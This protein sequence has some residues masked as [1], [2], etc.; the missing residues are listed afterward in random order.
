M[1]FSFVRLALAGLSAA[2]LG[3]IVSGQSSLSPVA[4]VCTAAPSCPTS[5]VSVPPAWYNLTFSTA[6]G[7]TGYGWEATEAGDASCAF[8]HQGIV[9]FNASLS[10]YV[11]LNNLTGTHTV[12]LAI[13]G[14]I[15]GPGAGSLAAGTQGWSFEATV[16]VH[17][18]LANSKIASIGAGAPLYNIFLSNDGTTNAGLNFGLFDGNT[19]GSV[20]YSDGH[21]AS[22]EFLNPYVQ[23]QW[24]H[25]VGVTQQV[26]SSNLM[27]NNATHGAWFIYVNG[28]LETFPTGLFQTNI[29]PPMVPRPFAYLGKSDWNDPY[30]SGLIDTFRI[31]N[32][33][34]TGAQVGQLYAGEMAGCAVPISTAAPTGSVFPNILPRN[35]TGPVTPIF[36]ANFSSNPLI[37]VT[38]ASGYG[39]AQSLSTD[40]PATQAMR[41]GLLTLTAA[42]S[43]YVNLSMPSGANSVGQVLPTVGGGT[44]GW[45]FELML[46]AYSGADAW[47]KIMDLGSTRNSSGIPINDIVLGWDGSAGAP[48]F[49]WQFD[50][51]DASYSDHEWQTG[52]A[53]GEVP[54][55]TWIHV[56]AAISP[57][58]SNGFCNYFT[59]LNGQLYTTVTGGFC[60]LAAVRQ[61][62]LIGKSGWSDPYFN[63][64]LD[65]FNVYAQQLSDTQ[66]AALYAASQV[67]QPAT[68]SSGSAA[69]GSTGGSV[70]PPA[71]GQSSLAY[72]P[73]ACTAAPACPA[74]P[75]A[76]PPAWYNLTFAT[77]P[78]TTPVSWSWESADA[79]DASCAFQHQGIATFN[80]SLA[81]FLDMN[82]ASGGNSS[83]L[84]I[85]GYIGGPSAGSLAAGTAGWSF[86]ATVR[87]HPNGGNAKIASIGAGAPLYNIFVSNDG[88]TNGGLNFGL[89]DGN[90]IGSVDYSAGHSGIIEYVTPYVQYQWYHLTAVLQ[91]I[92][93]ANLMENNV[94]HGA[95]FIYVNGQ[96]VSY[97]TG[98]TQNNMLPS[99]V[100]RPFS[101]LGKSDW[102]DPYWSGLIDTFR[103]YNYA[104][105]GAQVGQLYAGEMAGCAVPISTA[106]PTGS[107]YPNLLPRTAS[108]TV[109]PFFSAN[110]SSNP[111]TSVTGASGYGWAQSLSTDS[112]AN[113]ALRTGLLTLS[114]SSQ[115]VNLSMA[116]G[117]NSVGQVLPTIGGGTAGW[118]F[119]VMLISGSGADAWSKVYD[120]G[121]IRGSN[122]APVNDIVLGWDGSAGA[123]DTFWQFDV[124]DNSGV[125]HEWQTADAV[126][127]R[128]YNQW[129][130]IVAAISPPLNNSYC[131]YFTYVNGQLYT[132]INNGWCPL[133]APRQN[134]LLGKSGWNDP[135]FNGSIDFFNVYNQQLSD[136]QV[137]NLYSAAMGVQPVGGSS[138]GAVVAASSA[139]SAASAAASSG[140][141][142][143]ASS[144][145]AAAASSAAAPSAATSTPATQTSAPA[146]ATSAA[147]P[148]AASPTSAAASATSNPPSPTA[149]PTSAPV[150][151]ATSQ[152]G[153]PPSQPGNGAA[154]GQSIS[155]G[156]LPALA[157]I[158]LVA[159]LL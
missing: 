70:T 125:D 71:T 32:Y 114:G 98:G 96:L 115:Y 44:A 25:L 8:Q 128:V 106:A 158:A 94:T 50:V 159:C 14:L 82:L 156:L 150:I 6:P 138:S 133:A 33:A 15:G 117:A 121:T 129:T 78:A 112:A 86:E 120:L 97:P 55:N 136:V 122:G 3:T 51:C 31:Y 105:T 63:G 88:T 57:P 23:Y 12:G 13:P 93:T 109:A 144:S 141:V 92:T 147:S 155:S 87:V 1:R 123:P 21:S 102:N 104:L 113:Q 53:L 111:L 95:W 145:A 58:L 108:G 119:E 60:P 54:Y 41:T 56:V 131:N 80:A 29:L 18:D 24:Y 83:G 11:D 2:L 37:S 7:G 99:A 22:L 90:T 34:L 35:A 157:A 140:A 75:V 74:S 91:Q 10:Q 124:C 46:Q 135:Y 148:T 5:P 81:Q 26:T 73:T 110:F 151:A 137:A 4:T 48:D 49:F 66:I 17:P 154:A 143:A 42:S 79:G 149:A 130:H 43:Q 118:T 27:E 153:N 76:V 132:S 69:A 65:F 139:A 126:G 9:S 40:T 101:Y 36:S 64:A 38:G 152:A 103:I 39:W 85:P 146:A 61:N 84:A 116:S 52:D 67:A 62:A 100:P 77:A 142:V 59:Y 127:E 19:V 30:W 45:S 28:Q 72:V 107:V 47:S 68:S 16:R 89:Y 20:D 134:A